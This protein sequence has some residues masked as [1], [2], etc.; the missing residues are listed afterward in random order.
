MKHPLRL[1][2]ALAAL[3]LSLGGGAAD[4][5]ADV[6]KHAALIGKPAPDLQA[7]FAVN[8]KPLKLADLKGKVVLLTFWGP[9]SAPSRTAMLRLQEWYKEFLGKDLV[10]LAVTRYNSDYGRPFAFDKEAGTVVKAKTANRETDRQLLRDFAAYHKL[11]FCLM[12]LPKEE[13][14]R[15]YKEV[16]GVTTIPQF[17]LIDRGGRVR[18][19][20]AGAARKQF[21]AIDEEIR[22]LLVERK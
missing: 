2:G 12:E 18:M 10:I 13:A 1:T 15:L 19:V 17:V 3:A 21:E 6:K 5:R 7:D 9:W 16:Y 20:Q 11:E 14:E 8:G 22:K 4:V